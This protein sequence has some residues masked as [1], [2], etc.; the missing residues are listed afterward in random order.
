MR[1]GDFGALKVGLLF[2]PFS[3]GAP[4]EESPKMANF[5]VFA[6]CVISPTF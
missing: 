5:G 1:R 2:E 3:L 4:F 6:K